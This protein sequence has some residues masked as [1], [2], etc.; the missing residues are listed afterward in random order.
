MERIHQQNEAAEL[1]ALQLCLSFANTQKWHA[2]AHPVEQIGSYAELLEWARGAGLIGE[3]Q[4]QRLNET[5]AQQPG[6]A[7]AVFQSAL[8]LREAIYRI[9]TDLAHARPS[10]ESDLG[11]LNSALSDALMHA[12]VDAVGDEFEWGW[13]GGGQLD[14]IVWPIARSAGELLTSPWRARVG[15]CADDRGCG[16]LFIDTSKNHSRRWCDINDCGNRAKA[17]RHYQRVREQRA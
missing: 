12:R 5:A 15:Q 9:F 1:E 11:L 6:A 8:A 2:S 3:A 7:E 16:W 17:R 14:R 4:M 10:E 13:S